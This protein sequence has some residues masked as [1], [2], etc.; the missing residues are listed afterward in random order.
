MSKVVILDAGH[1]GELNGVY[2]TSG[3]RSPVWED[4]TQYFEGVGNRQIVHAASQYLERLGWTVLYTVHPNDPS[5]VSLS[6][7]IKISNSHFQRYPEAFQISV[8][9]NGF[10]KESANGYEVFTSKGQTKSDK[11]ATVW[12]DEMRRAFPTLNNRGHKEA[13]F[14]MNRVHCPSILI[15][16]M[17]HTNR[18]ECEIL[19]SESGREKIAIAIVETCERVHKEL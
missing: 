17:F 7:R 2:Q 11:I 3:K 19:M 10:I 12:I 6:Q 18:K 9:S 16:S 15:E 1:G 8:H 13:N 5:D 4:G 14:A